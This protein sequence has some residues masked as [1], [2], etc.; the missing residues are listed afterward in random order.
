MTTISAGQK[1]KQFAWLFCLCIYD[2]I[3][4]FSSCRSAMYF[5][6]GLLL[7]AFLALDLIFQTHEIKTVIFLPFLFSVMEKLHFYTHILS[8]AF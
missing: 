6:V 5:T 1:V 7:A 3:F 2:W 8:N 4:A